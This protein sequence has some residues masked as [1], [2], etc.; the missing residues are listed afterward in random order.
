MDRKTWPNFKLAD[1]EGAPHPLFVWPP[2]NQNLGCLVIRTFRCIWIWFDFN[3]YLGYITL[4]ICSRWNS[5]YC[6]FNISVNEGLKRRLKAFYRGPQFS[7]ELPFWVFAGICSYHL[8]L[9]AN[10]EKI[11][12][13]YILGVISVASLTNKTYRGMPYLMRFSFTNPYPLGV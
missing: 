4:H 5:F 9:M 11:T 3:T 1:S 13:A 10:Q 8:V 12:M 2:P 7:Y 6:P